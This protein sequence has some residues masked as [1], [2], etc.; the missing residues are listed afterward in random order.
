LNE[1]PCN[2][3]EE[4]FLDNAVLTLKGWSP[5]ER[6]KVLEHLR[7]AGT[8]PPPGRLLM[9]WEEAREM[10]ASGLI[11]F[12]AHT[13]N[14][15]ILDQVPQRQAE[16]EI[17]RSLQELESR[18]G[19]RPELFAYPNGNVTGDL[20][21]ILKRNGFRGAV[22]TRKGLIGE[23]VSLFEIPRIG[24]HEDVSRTIPLFLARIL[25]KRF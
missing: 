4:A 12:G 13:V 22:T 19:V 6:E 10:Q 16:E 20:R 1:V 23:G 2:S 5:H 25:L 24:M 18:L 14:H 8:T 9:N 11:T 15:V 3:G 21:A 17:V 7:S